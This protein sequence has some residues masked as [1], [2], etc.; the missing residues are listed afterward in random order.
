MP[1]SSILLAKFSA[2]MRLNYSLSWNIEASYWTAFVCEDYGLDES[3]AVYVADEWREYK[4]CNII[5]I[6]TT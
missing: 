4:L 1:S 3:Y 2:F 6:Q 5:C